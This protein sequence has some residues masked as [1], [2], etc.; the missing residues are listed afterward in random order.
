VPLAI[1]ATGPKMIRLAAE[2]ADGVL[3]AVGA[4]PERLR[5]S[6]E[7]I[8]AT[9]DAAGLGA[10]EFSVSAYVCVIPDDDRA[11]ARKMASGNVA[12]FA[13]FSSMHGNVAST[14]PDADRAIY[15]ALHDSYTMRGHMRDGSPQSTQLTDEFIDRF[16][17]VGPAEECAE[18]LVE[19]TALGIHRFLVQPPGFGIDPD[20]MRR[21]MAKDVLPAVRAAAASATV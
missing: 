12:S 15:Q 16:A 4:E 11:R 8:R 10:A 7:A 3:L 17:V 6:I 14:V 9:R 20:E 21:R 18:R 2:V 19:L 13:R 1:A 5:A